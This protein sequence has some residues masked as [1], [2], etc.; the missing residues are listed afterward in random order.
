MNGLWL[1]RWVSVGS[2]CFGRR[3][4]SSSRRFIAAFP[5]QFVKGNSMTVIRWGEYRPQ[6]LNGHYVTNFK[7]TVF[8]LQCDEPVMTT[9][10]QDEDNFGFGTSRRSEKAFQSHPQSNQTLPMPKAK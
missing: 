3:F 10:F 9:Y 2:I 8:I 5:R 6:F 7:R 1:I 4:R